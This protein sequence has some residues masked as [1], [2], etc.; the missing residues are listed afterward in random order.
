MQY[1]SLTKEEMTAKFGGIFSIVPSGPERRQAGGHYGTMVFA[2]GCFQKPV[3]RPDEVAFY[4]AG[5]CPSPLFLIF[6]LKRFHSFC[7]FFQ[8][9]RLNLRSSMKST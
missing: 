4:E 5:L 7:S 2:D 6:F 1:A 3:R 9:K 8:P